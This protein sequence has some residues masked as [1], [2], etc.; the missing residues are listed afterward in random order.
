MEGEKYQNVPVGT[1]PVI[2][3]CGDEWDSDPKWDRLQNLFLDF[4]RGDT[5][6]KS[7]RL[8]GLEL[9]IQMTLING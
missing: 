5:N 7:I 4:F 3:F 1:K 6:V 9:F 8:K 2:S